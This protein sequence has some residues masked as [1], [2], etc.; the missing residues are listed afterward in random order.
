VVLGA[1]IFVLVN[2]AVDLVY[3]ILDPRIVVR[4]GRP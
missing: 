3:P 2:L 4:T 1:L